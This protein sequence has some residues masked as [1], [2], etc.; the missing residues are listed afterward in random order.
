MHI[1]FITTGGS[2]DK[3]YSLEASDFVVGPPQI[4]TVMKEVNASVSYS[5]ESLFR[6]DSLDITDDDRAILYAQ[7]VEHPSDRIIVTHGTDTMVQSAQYLASIPNKTIVFTGAMQPAAFKVTDAIFNIGC[8]VMAVQLLS[9][10]VYVVMNGQVL[11]PA[12]AAK[13]GNRFE[14]I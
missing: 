14:L 9:E 10:G 12:R 8:A 7:V 1:H 11:D 6:K 4:A 5:V 2:I 13:R 3:T